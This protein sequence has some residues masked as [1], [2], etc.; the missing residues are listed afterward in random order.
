MLLVGDIN[1]SVSAAIGFIALFGI[2]VENGVVLV[3]FFDQLVAEGRSVAEA[4]RHG[5]SLRLRPLLMTTMTTLLGL[6][7]MLLASGAGAEIQRPLAAVVL[8]GLVTSTILT[9]IVLPTF[10]VWL[11]GG[12]SRTQL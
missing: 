2:A 9:L 7:P 1:L 8:G 5:C 3:A 12:K 10:Y 11:I 6:T 4:V